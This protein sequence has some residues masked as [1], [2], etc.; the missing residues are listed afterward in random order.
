MHANSPPYTQLHFLA[1]TWFGAFYEGNGS[2]HRGLG[3]HRRVRDK[4]QWRY[5]LPKDLDLIPS[6][7]IAAHE[8]F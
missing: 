5:A 1:L 4:A 7:H 3:D 8:L 2:A 6:T